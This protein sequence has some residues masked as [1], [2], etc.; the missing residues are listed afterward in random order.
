MTLNSSTVH[1]SCE[2]C[3]QSWFFLLSKD[4]KKGQQRMVLN[5]QSIKWLKWLMIDTWN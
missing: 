3:L 2:C 4:V 5:V 1:V